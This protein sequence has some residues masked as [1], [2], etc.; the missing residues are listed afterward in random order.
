MANNY[1]QFSE[2]LPNLKPAE[3]GWLKRQLEQVYVLDG[4]EFS[5]A[6]II[7]QDLDSGPDPAVPDFVG[8]R[9]FR[10]L[11]GYDPDSDEGTGF[12]YEFCDGDKRGWG[13]HLWVYADEGGDVARVAHL[14]RKFL[15]QFRPKDCWSLTYATTCS[16]SRVGEFGGGAVFVTAARIRWQNGYEFVD[17]CRQ[18]VEAARPGRTH[19]RTR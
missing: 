11:K 17:K 12:Q 8:C 10:D 9:V 16:K 18:R 14:I 13:S 4:K 5:P 3:E 19:K 6:E 15:K 2:V 1:L 7:A